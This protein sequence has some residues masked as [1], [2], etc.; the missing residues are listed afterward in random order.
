MGKPENYSSMTGSPFQRIIRKSAWM[1][2][3]NKKLIANWA[4]GNRQKKLAKHKRKP[5][6]VLWTNESPFASIYLHTLIDTLW[7]LRRNRLLLG[8]V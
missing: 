5:R 6:A 2:Q 1:Q 8:K 3:W 7:A 4:V